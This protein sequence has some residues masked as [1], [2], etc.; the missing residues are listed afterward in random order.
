MLLEPQHKLVLASQKTCNRHH[1]KDLALKLVRAMCFLQM[2]L[3]R[4]KSIYNHRLRLFQLSILEWQQLV[5]LFIKD[6]HLTSKQWIKAKRETLF[7][8]KIS[9]MLKSFLKHQVL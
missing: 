9:L 4:K 6:T 3:M 5:S 7:W 2:E 1:K 8:K